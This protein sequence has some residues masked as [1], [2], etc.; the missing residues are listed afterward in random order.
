MIKR[1]RIPLLLI[2]LTSIIVLSYMVYYHT[3]EQ[4]WTGNCMAM[5]CKRSR[6]SYRQLP[7][8]KHANSLVLSSKSGFGSQMIGISLAIAEWLYSE[9]CFIINEQA[10]ALSDEYGH[11]WYHYFKSLYNGHIQNI[12]LSEDLFYH[13]RLVNNSV[14]Q[15]LK[16]NVF[17]DYIHFKDDVLSQINHIIAKYPVS[18]KVATI[19]YRTGDKYLE[20]KLSGEYY[21]FSNQLLDWDGQINLISDDPGFSQHIK[22]KFPDVIEIQQRSNQ[23]FIIKDFLLLKFEDKKTDLLAF[24]AKLLICVSSDKVIATNI[25]N[26][27][28]LCEILR[29]SNNFMFI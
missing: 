29:K 4:Y 8:C 10:S 5:E 18:D 7:I 17:R 12:N 14:T 19:I 1:F 24:L 22:D 27:S 26:I 15:S 6:L 28:L 2:I 16:Y 3:P 25:S 11:F 21:K 9:Q 23:G 13:D 20:N